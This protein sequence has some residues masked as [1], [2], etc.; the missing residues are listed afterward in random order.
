MTDCTSLQVDGSQNGQ[1]CNCL[2]SQLGRQI[3]PHS[4]FHQFLAML[5]G[6]P[7]SNK[8]IFFLA[9]C[10]TRQSVSVLEKPKLANGC[11]LQQ[12]QQLCPMS[13][14]LWCSRWLP[15]TLEKIWLLILQ[16]KIKF[17][18]MCWQQEKALQ[19]PKNV[20]WNIAGAPLTC[21]HKKWLNDQ[22]K[23]DQVD[24]HELDPR[25]TFCI[26]SWSH[27][28]ADAWRIATVLVIWHVS[29]WWSWEPICVTDTSLSFSTTWSNN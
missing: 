22:H 24:S 21:F 4:L 10:W 3:T 1:L 16:R 18:P 17:S 9:S 6:R 2:C 25:M 20:M 19:L 13:E 28:L 12:H 14:R 27:L 8:H 23:K 11:H 15:C 26:A 5:L 29:S 7:F